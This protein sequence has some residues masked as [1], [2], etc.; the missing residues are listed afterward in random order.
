MSTYLELC[1]KTARDA[2]IISGTSELTTVSETDTMLSMVIDWVQEAWVDIQREKSHWLFQY[3]EFSAILTIGIQTYDDAALSITRLNR[4]V[5]DRDM[6]IYDPAI[7][8]ADEQRITYVPYNEFRSQ[9][10]RG[11]PV[12][13]RPQYVTVEPDNTLSFY[14]VP[15][16]AYGVKGEYYKSAQY[17]TANGDIPDMPADYHSLIKWKAL[18]TYAGYDEATQQAGFWL[19]KERS[20]RADLV[21]DQLPKF[22]LGGPLT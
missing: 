22:T 12:D 9:F 1:Q 16:K 18:G 2:S 13:G 21:R 14:P 17:L 15:D 19:Q 7:G 20:V 4:W 11:V 5:T 3:A 6:W 10:Q 8:A